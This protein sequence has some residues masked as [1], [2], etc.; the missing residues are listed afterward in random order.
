[1]LYSSWT[2]RC[3][4]N[5]E[6]TNIL[7]GAYNATL[8][9]M[10]LYYSIIFLCLLSI[11]IR[12]LW[13]F[14]DFVCKCQATGPG[15]EETNSKTGGIDKICSYSCNCMAWENNGIPRP[16]IR[17]EVNKLPTTA[18]SREQ[19]DHGSHICHGQYSYRPKLTDENWKIQVRFDEFTLLSSGS[20]W[21][22]EDASREIAQGINYQGFTYTHK[23]P[24]ISTAL[25]KMFKTK[26]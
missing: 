12:P 15:Y 25:K 1:M 3:V 9:A 2:R 20:V 19:W 10:R 21:Y 5:V 16:N 17:L 8:W 23:A 6:N 26:F 4:Q 11:F 18:V 22:P 7:S 14:D 13:A 24:E